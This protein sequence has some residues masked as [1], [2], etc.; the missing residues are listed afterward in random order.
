MTHYNGTEIT[1]ADRE[2]LVKRGGA[3]VDGFTHSTGVEGYALSSGVR[4]YDTPQ[5]TILEQPRNM[6]DA[7]R[8]IEGGP[9]AF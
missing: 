2:Y 6:Q 5:G 8:L 3:L 7:R 9:K 1:P 4:F